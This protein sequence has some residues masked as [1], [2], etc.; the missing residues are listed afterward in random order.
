MSEHQSDHS[1]DPDDGLD[2]LERTLL[3]IETQEILRETTSEDLESRGFLGDSPDEVPEK[4]RRIPTETERLLFEPKIQYKRLSGK[5]TAQTIDPDSLAH[6][7]D[8][9]P[10]TRLAARKKST[11]NPSFGAGI[12][13]VCKE[14]DETEWFIASAAGKVIIDRNSLCVVS[15]AVDHKIDLTVTDDHMSVVMNCSP[16]RGNGSPL[17]IDAVRQLLAERGIT[18]GVDYEA[19]EKAVR[20]ANSSLS[21]QTGV[22][23]A[24][25]TPPINGKPGRIKY[26]FKN[27]DPEHNFRVLEDGRIDYKG[28]ANVPAVREGQLLAEIK[29]PT[30]GKKGLTVYGK[31]IPP[32]KGKPAVLVADK[33]V[34]TNPCGNQFYAETDGCVLLNPPSISVAEIY[35]IN[36]DV[37]Y[38]TGSIHFDGSVVVNGTVRDG[39]EVKASGDI[40]VRDSVESARLEAG[41]D[42]VVL[43]GIQGHGKGLIWAGRNIQCEFAQN[44]RLEAQES[45]IV[46]DF[47]V[48]SYVFCNHLEALEGHGSI[49]GGEVYAR[50]IVDVLVIGSPAGTATSVSAG[51]DYLVRRSIAETEEIIGFCDT[52]IKKIDSTLR[53][54]LTALRKNPSRAHPRKELIDQTLEK[55]K[56]L[57]HRKEMLSAKRDHL[58]EKLH[59]EGHCFIRAKR[60]CYSDV[61][62]RIR[63]TK[64]VV[65]TERQNIRFYEDRETDAIRTAP[66]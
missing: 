14:S 32:A 31:S 45:V 3:D 39:F 30:K 29:A 10:G 49:V 21:D 34:I 60:S 1:P 52:N 24:V 7:P 5:E 15:S 23:I 48:N 62:L 13:V 16:A 51:T 27:A 59:L 36:G 8:V 38:S 44:A 66:Y 41:R 33:G 37:D 4:T 20:Q 55:R 40:T 65:R 22:Q 53:P 46:R 58:K 35:T 11:G 64:T 61:R 9:T 18:Q 50:R 12:N 43:R 25:G 6:L 57:Q 63:E 2:R 56:A 28:T 17:T 47:L 42:V 54:V 26:E 19:I